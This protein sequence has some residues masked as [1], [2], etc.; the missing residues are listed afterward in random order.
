MIAYELAIYFLNH[1]RYITDSG[2][3]FGFMFIFF[4]LCLN[5]LHTHT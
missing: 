5:A 4:P 1:T 2:R 3:L